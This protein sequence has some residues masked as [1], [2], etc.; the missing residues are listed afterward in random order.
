M[1]KQESSVCQFQLPVLIAGAGPCG[2]VAA[3]TF[4][5]RG[6][7]F[8]ILERASRSKI[9]SNAGSGFEL[10]PTAV[11]ILKE[12]LG[13]D[14][15]EIMSSYGGVSIMTIEG[16]TIRKEGF[17][18]SYD[19]GSVNRTEMQQYLLDMI[20]PSAEDEKDVLLCGSG[21]ESY[22]ELVNTNT[23][24]AKLTSGREIKGCVLLACDGIHS[25]CRAI[26]H[27]GDNNGDGNNPNPTST[28]NQNQK[29][30]DP[31]RYCNAT[32]YW[33]K[34][35]APNGSALQTEFLKTQLSPT[36]T[37]VLVGIAT[38]KV[39]VNFYIIPS[40]QNT[41]LLWDITV[42]SETPTGDSKSG[43]GD[44]TR[45]GGSVLTQADKEKLLSFGSSSSN[46][47]STPNSDSDSDG[48]ILKGIEDFPLLERILEQTP[49]KDITQAGFFDRKNLNL[50]Y[51]S[52]KKLVAL[53]GDA[54]HPQTPYLGQGVNMAITDAY[55][56][57][58]ILSDSLNSQKYTLTRAM[59]L[60]DTDSR[61]K[62]NKKAVKKARTICN[63]SNSS[64]PI[65]CWVLRL[66]YK[67]ISSEE[68]LNQIGK[69]DGSN[70]AY[71]E[72]F[73]SLNNQTTT[74]V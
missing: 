6:V 65:I 41:V 22:H 35:L 1:T 31:L 72:Y 55:V 20:F 28:T 30:K 60:C 66:L 32:C 2:L 33:G 74:V 53:L 19:G 64:N 71:W 24:V 40:K 17:T 26:M 52:K 23:V 67:R 14:I 12:G 27:G 62:A 58:N 42:A 73:Q 3:A 36:K 13:V 16:E 56:Y 57:A 25:M 18:K 51:T 46:K 9:C 21:V 45:R 54:A 15:N 63:F 49:A 47:S 34:T 11:Q 8:V 39:P 48:S 10:A 37:S 38:R 43:S 69:T 5:K 7:P 44:L 50:P 61:R 29:N 59:E 4:Q 68:L 70:R